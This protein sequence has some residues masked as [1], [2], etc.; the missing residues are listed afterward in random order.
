MKKKL[1]P[2]TI[3]LGLLAASGMGLTGCLDKGLEELPAFEEAKIINV[4]T[5]YRFKDATAKNTVGSPKVIVVNLPVARTLKLR[6][7][8]PGA[9][10]DSVLLEVTVPQASGVFSAA[11]RGKVS[12]S[13]LVMYS[14]ISTAADIVPLAG[15]P[16]LGVPGDFSAP[17]QYQVTAADGKNSRVW[18][19]KVTKIIK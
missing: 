13:D 6:E 5:E 12:A 15:S 3:F 10:T 17:R 16:A 9:A 14:N 19:I 7:S 2:N 1:I 18:T 8:T 11:E 4:F